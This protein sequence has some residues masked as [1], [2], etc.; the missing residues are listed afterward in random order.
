M[1]AKYSRRPSYLDGPLSP[2]IIPE[3]AILPQ[4]LPAEKVPCGQLVS[5][6]SKYTSKALEDRDY[7]DI[8]T[9][10]YKDVI[11]FNAENGHFVESFG[12]THLLQKPLDEGTEAGTIEAEEQ[13]VRLLK[14]ADAALQKV[15]QDEEAR[16]WIKEQDE[17]GFVVAQRQVSNAS[18]KRARLVDIGN[19]NWEVVREVG[20]E[21]AAGKRRDSGLPI[22]TNSKWDVVGVVLKKIIVEGDDV[23]LGDELGAQYWKQ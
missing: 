9:R 20:N 19:N 13:S 2:S 16:K 17:A 15:W 23:K 6:T 14:D 1:A 22:D 3:L 21:D 18:Y 12:G 5:K 11:F 7:D 8:G 4:P 10:W